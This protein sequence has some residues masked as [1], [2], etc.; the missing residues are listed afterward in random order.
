MLATFVVVT[1]AARHVVPR[2]TDKAEK[3][4]ATICG[5]AIGVATR[6][7]GHARG[8][9]PTLAFAG[10]GVGVEAH[11]ATVA[12]A[13]RT[14]N[15]VLLTRFTS[16]LRADIPAEGRNESVMRSLAF[17]YAVSICCVWV[18]AGFF[19]D[20]WAHGHVP[21]ETF[22]TPYHAVFYSGMLVLFCIIAG[23]AVRNRA[24]GLSWAQSVPAPYRLAILGFPIFVLAGIGDLL[25]H[26]LLGIEVGIDALLS[27]THQALGL[28]MFFLASGPIRS[29]LANR[30]TSTTLWR[31][32]PFV[33]GL[34]A[35]YGLVHFGTAYA[36][37]PGAA[38]ADAPPSITFSPNYM[39]ALALAYYKVAIGVLVLIFQ[40]ALTAG[41]ALWATSSLRL[42]PGVF[43][44]LYPCANAM[45]AAPFT[46]S[47]PLLAVTLVASLVTGVAADVMV[48]R[49]DPQP[50]RPCAYRWFAALVPMIYAATFLIGTD[51]TSGL[52]WDWNVALGAWCWT[53]VA[54]F[55]LSFICLARR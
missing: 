23:F 54:G 14:N 39:T 20:A 50:S 12:A 2:G 44:I 29:T 30:A 36:F 47:T 9:C 40:A 6:G 53:G 38:R 8:M 28:G 35:W 16:R 25:W 48:A 3:Y 5:C 11:A 21:I 43:T 46:N 18:V 10:S 22:F 1:K 31:Q 34:V 33:F 45:A 15:A 37:I 7:D 13:A 4:I 55:G 51:V 49:L 42:R 52:W 26:M 17:D 24:G 27:P 32:L 41:F 19:L